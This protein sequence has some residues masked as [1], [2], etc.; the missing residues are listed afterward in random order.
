VIITNEEVEHCVTG[1]TS[2][3]LDDLVRDRGNSRISDCDGVE[4]LEVVNEAQRAV[5][6]LDA[7]PT[8]AVRGVRVLVYSGVNFLLE[9]F[10][11][12]V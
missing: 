6:L 9:E 10:D 1:T 7:E 11:D 2:H 4:R 3:G 12:F 5:L 8:G